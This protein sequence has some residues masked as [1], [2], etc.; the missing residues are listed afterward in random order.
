M[1]E[2]SLKLIF[3]FKAVSVCASKMWIELAN[4][5][6]GFTGYKH[7]PHADITTYCLSVCMMSVSAM[8]IRRFKLYVN[9]GIENEA[10]A[11]RTKNTQKSN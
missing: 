9:S 1:S 5:R 8:S 4:Q 3:Y 7:K 6:V 10:S 2:I 11:S